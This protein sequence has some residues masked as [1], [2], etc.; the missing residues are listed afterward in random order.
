[1]V[2]TAFSPLFLDS[3][4]LFL[5]MNADEDPEEA[6]LAIFQPPKP[7]TESLFVLI[8]PILYIYVE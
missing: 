6:K 2:S 8:S 3:L 4:A 1:M 7:D 5:K